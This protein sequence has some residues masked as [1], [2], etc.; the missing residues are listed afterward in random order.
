M[1]CRA[2]SEKVARRGVEVQISEM[3]RCTGA[4]VH[5]CTGAELQILLM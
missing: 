4:Q 3:L 5:R 2:G 1:Q